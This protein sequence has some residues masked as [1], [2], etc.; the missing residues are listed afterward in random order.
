MDHFKVFTEFLTILLLFCFGFLAM[1]HAGSQI[2]NQASNPHPLHWKVESWPLDCWGRPKIYFLREE[3]RCSR[4]IKPSC[5]HILETGV[6]GLSLAEAP[7]ARAEDTRLEGM[8]WGW[9]RGG[10]DPEEGT[11][12]VMF[13]RFIFTQEQGA[14][15]EK[16]RNEYLPHKIVPR[17]QHRF[18]R[19][20]Q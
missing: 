10:A 2:P 12:N 5:A 9:E 15:L 6:W 13:K 20:R 3:E 19:A 1:R 8:R 14:R 7:A 4:H 18:I 17:T 11:L 16:V